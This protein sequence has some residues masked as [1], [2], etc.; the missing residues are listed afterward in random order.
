MT[1]GKLLRCDG[2]QI[3]AY[4]FSS[5][6]GMV[7]PDRRNTQEIALYKGY[8]GDYYI[9]SNHGVI[10]IKNGRFWSLK[11]GNSSYLESIEGDFVALSAN[12][13]TL[14]WTI[15][16]S[17]H[18]YL[19][20][21]YQSNCIVEK[22]RGNYYRT[23]ID[24]NL[25]I[26][27]DRRVLWFNKSQ[28]K[29]FNVN[30]LN[31]PKSVS[32]ANFG[33]FRDEY[34]QT[35][36]FP[37]R[38][39]DWVL[40]KNLTLSALADSILTKRIE[41]TR[42]YSANFKPF[43]IHLSNNLMWISNYDQLKLYNF[44]SPKFQGSRHY[45]LATLYPKLYATLE[46]P[47]V[48][49]SSED[50]DDNVWFGTPFFDFVQYDSSK[51]SGIVIPP[52]IHLKE[53]KLSNAAPNWTKRDSL[54]D[55]GIRF[56][57]WKR[58]SYPPNNLVL[59]HN[60]NTITFEFIGI[61]HRAPEKVRYQYRLETSS[62]VTIWSS[63]SIDIEASF[64]NLQAGDYVFWVKACSVDGVWS[65]PIRYAFVIQPPWWQ[66]TPFIV[67][68]MFFLIV[69]S[70]L[71]ASR[72]GQIKR[73]IREQAIEEL[74]RDLHDDTR[75]SIFTLQQLIDESSDHIS[76]PILIK[77]YLGKMKDYVLRINNDLQLFIKAVK[78]HKITL[79]ET[80]LEVQSNAVGAVFRFGKPDF[81]MKGVSKVKTMFHGHVLKG[82]E[83]REI[84]LIFKEAMTNAKKY[85]KSEIV[86]F[87]LAIDDKYA[88]MSISDDGIGFDLNAEIEGN[89]LINMKKRAKK[90]DAM[91][92]IISIPEE[93]TKVTL[94]LPLKTQ[95]FIFS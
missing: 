8:N 33:I 50:E 26:F 18:I 92:E 93:G 63:V 84:Q 47:Y 78:D 37:L 12:H 83:S 73:R 75:N 60:K 32:Q 22:K 4:S 59:P 23:L 27:Y 28:A 2:K 64:Y 40:N 7:F 58:F 68:T 29:S 31:L 44:G 54:A 53:V 81:Y 11:L 48:S 89:G 41:V 71:L 87:E 36:I 42:K 55:E 51:D 45:S 43:D 80:V 74:G 16:D 20:R 65:E 25:V 24:N 90:I 85:S 79:L 95:R 10:R 5:S 1:H 62:S 56:D 14:S 49:F 15:Q 72:Y 21:C 57:E 88:I 30:K 61:H 3:L 46:T 34:G 67:S 94:K 19:T 13:D 38:K 6:H 76:S 52:I 17:A 91:L 82:L 9:T 69:S 35:W 70:L 86:C 66:A 39:D 77:R